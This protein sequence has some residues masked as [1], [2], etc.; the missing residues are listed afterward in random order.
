M[1][2]LT[3]SMNL[4]PSGPPQA[5]ALALLEHWGKAGFLRHVD[6][7]AEFYAARR[8]SFEAKVHKV[9]GASKDGSRPAVAEWVSPVAGMFLWLQ[10]KLPP[11]VKS[12]DG[13]SK[14]LIE[15]KARA[16]G[17]LGVPGISFLPGAEQTHYVR[18]SFSVV[19]EDQVERGF[20]A[21]RSAIEEAW[22]EAGLELK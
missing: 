9:L 16:K 15:T 22:K 12:K 4:Q 11:S 21:L 14:D 10:L 19:P 3:A 13:D 20:E 6:R 2:L 8:N 7:V 5:L 18:T 1:D 17:F